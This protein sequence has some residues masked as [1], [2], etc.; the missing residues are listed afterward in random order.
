M[1]C[2]NHCMIAIDRLCYDVHKGLTLRDTGRQ[3]SCELSHAASPAKTPC[4][5]LNGRSSL[6]VL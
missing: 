3:S 2:I 1:S 5:A 4:D 6:D